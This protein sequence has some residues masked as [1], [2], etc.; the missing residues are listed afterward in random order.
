MM[1]GTVTD[2]SYCGSSS[3]K[4]FVTRNARLITW[5]DSC[6][7]ESCVEQIKGTGYG[8]ET[9]GSVNIYSRWG[10]TQGLFVLPGRAS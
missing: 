9:Q 5:K 8:I 7:I 10:K 2:G 1:Q 3:V 6:I 4:L